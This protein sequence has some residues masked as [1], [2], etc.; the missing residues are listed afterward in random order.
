ML[1][2]LADKATSVFMKLN[3]D[4]LRR[5]ITILEDELRA[6]QEAPAAAYR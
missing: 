6:V 4:E 5:R 1:A 2:E 3:D